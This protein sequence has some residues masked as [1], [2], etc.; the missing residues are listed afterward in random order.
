VSI[1][2]NAALFGDG[3]VR[4]PVDLDGATVFF[5]LLPVTAEISTEYNKRRGQDVKEFVMRAPEEGE[6]PKLEP[7]R[8]TVSNEQELSARRWLAEKVVKGWDEG[9][10]VTTDGQALDFDQKTLRMIAAV[11]AIIDPVFRAAERLGEI[12]VAAEEGN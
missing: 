5:D 9:V 11:P 12:K 6:G 1:I 7:M 4:T 10:L 2:I 8:W 3:P